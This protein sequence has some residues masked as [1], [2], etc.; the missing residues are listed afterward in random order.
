[1][2]QDKVAL[3]GGRTAGMVVHVGETVRRRS[4]PN[5]EFVRSLLKHLES[6]GFDGAPRHLGI[7]EEGLEIFTYVRG[8]VPAE[9]GRYE[10]HTLQEAAGL[11][12]RYHDASTAL[13]ATPAARAAGIEVACHNDLSPCNTVFRRGRPVAFI[14]F[15]AAAP[16]SRAYDLAYALWLWLDLG[17]PNYSSEEQLRRSSLFL[18]AYG[19]APRRAEV[20]KSVLLRQTILIAEATRI[21][22][23]DMGRWAKNCRRWT[24]RHFSGIG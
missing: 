15:D 18:A 19:R 5:A 1:M 16:G 9:L 13:F 21:G 6:S 22:N 14:D 7:D 12:R 23:I 8:T 24:A 11:I 17:S 20:F 10:D 3:T 2:S 4:T